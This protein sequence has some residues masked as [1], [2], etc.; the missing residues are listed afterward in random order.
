MGD[1]LSG[2]NPSVDPDSRAIWTSSAELGGKD[3]TTNKGVIKTA[4][5]L[6]LK[7]A[8]LLSG[9]NLYVRELNLRRRGHAGLRTST[10]KV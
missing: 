6:S 1:P 8:S 5:M 4:M 10:Y 7:D 3:Q 2:M 9:M